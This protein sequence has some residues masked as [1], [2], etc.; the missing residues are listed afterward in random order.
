MTIESYLKDH[1]LSADFLLDYGVAWDENYLNIPIKDEQGNLTFIKARNLHY[2]EEGNTDPKY[3]N[4]TGSKAT[5]FNYHNIKDKKSVIITEGEIDALK[6]TQEGIP[7]VSS[8][9]GAGTFKPE[10]VPLLTNKNIWIC[11]DN[12]EAGSKGTTDLL[13]YFPH[14]KVIQLPKKT[15]DI[16]DYFSNKKSKKK[17]TKE[18]F[19]K[20]PTL[21]ATQWKANHLPEDFQILT[22]TDLTT[23]EFPEQAWLIKD[24]IYSEGFC[25]IYGAEGTGKSFLTLSLAKAI[26]EGND[27]LGEFEVESPA[28]VLFL[29][30]ENPLSM[31]SRRIKG[32]DINTGGNIQWLKYPDKFQ[33][34]DGKGNPSEFALAVSSIVARDD[35]KLIII[36]SFVDLMVGSESSAED[37]QRFFDGLRTLFP[38]K[39]FLAL[40]HENKPSQGVF[41]NDSQRLRGSSNINAQTFTQF[42]L[43]TVG[44]SKIDMTLKQTKA[45]DSVKLD[46]F[47]IQMQVGRDDNGESI[48]TGFKYMGSIEEFVDES[49]S[50][51][52]EEVIKELIRQGKQVSRK[53]IMDTLANYGSSE[54]TIRRSLSNLV[55]GGVLSMYKKGKENWYTANK[56]L[57]KEDEIRLRD[58]QATKDFSGGLGFG[59]SEEELP[60]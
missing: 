46:K 53:D 20:L 48:V 47:M 49:K 43:E 54:S 12:D 2:K 28:K 19:L 55:S 7:A 56:L 58:A 36:D 9:N 39:A 35:I 8:T 38:N 17:H 59:D 13:N 44:S 29:D 34:S 26:A 31:V 5:L 41:R 10:W 40:H 52:S 3:K 51:E 14:A 33:L 25:F 1:T 6:L 37:T 60:Y 50:G 32:L 24:I 23:M 4:P 15:K 45:R 27:W 30:K 21:T 42:R 22:D 16:C 57:S 11:L 18:S